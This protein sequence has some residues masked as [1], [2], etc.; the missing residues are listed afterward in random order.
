MKLIEMLPN[1]RYKLLVS[2]RFNW[3]PRGPIQRFFEK[4]LQSDFFESAFAR[5]DEIKIF[6]T[7][8][9]SRG[10]IDEIIRK[11]KK[12]GDEVNDLHLDDEKLGL[13]ERK[14]VSV[15]LAVRPWETKAFSALRRKQ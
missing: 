3:I 15:V 12:L 5:K 4:N 6:V 8:M 13:D 10:S 14:G 11:V 1:N 2:K 9:L 7:S